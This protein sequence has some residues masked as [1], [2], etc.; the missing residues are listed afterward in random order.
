MGSRISS[1]KLFLV[2]LIF[3]YRSVIRLN[4]YKLIDMILLFKFYII[5]Q[6]SSS[7]KSSF[8]FLKPFYLLNLP[9]CFSFSLSILGLGLL[10]F[11]CLPSNIYPSKF[12]A[13]LTS[14]SVKHNKNPKPLPYPSSFLIWLNSANLIRF[15]LNKLYSLFML[16]LFDKFPMN[17]SRFFLLYWAF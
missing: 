15:Y 12:I 1:I 7:K 3:I 6:K 16:G 13:L 9:F 14:L 5:I 17:S 4:K 2:S 8:D 11:N 10:I